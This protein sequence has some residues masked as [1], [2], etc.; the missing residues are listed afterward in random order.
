[1]KKSR[2]LSALL[3]GVVLLLSGCGAAAS[4]EE[5]RIGALTGPTVMGMVHLPE[6]APYSLSLYGTADELT[7]LILQ[8]ELDIA[9]VPLN[10]ASVLYNKTDGAVELAAV[11]VRGVLYIC[12]YGSEEIASFADLRGKT[13]YAT[14]KGAVPE[15]FLRYALRQSGLDADTDVNLV[16]KS[17]PAEVAALLEAEGQGI[18]MLPQ[19][20]VTAAEA[21]LPGLR[22]VLSLSSAWPEGCTAGVI[23]RREFAR[24]NP[25]AVESFLDDLSS[26]AYWVTEHPQEAGQICGE[27]GFIKAPL[28]EKAIPYCGL[29]CLTGADMRAA[30]EGTLSVIYEQNAAAVG[31]AMPKEAFYYAAQ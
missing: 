9:A 24:V 11:N 3:A 21:Q 18:A 5:I 17:E 29:A 22:A 27:L 7:P 30:A 8:G 14:G 31:G 23:V 20:Y 2:I 13:V 12:E 28:A 15:Y 1:M 6:E 25:E 26:S 10:L 16:W 19:P 4:A